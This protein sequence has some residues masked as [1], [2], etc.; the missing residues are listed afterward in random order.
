[1]IRALLTFEEAH[2]VADARPGICTGA[3]RG[4]GTQMA[5]DLE[6]SRRGET[7]AANA[8]LAFAAGVVQAPNA[9]DRTG[10]DAP[11]D[12]DRNVA[13]IA[14]H[15]A[16]LAL[17]LPTLGRIAYGLELSGDAAWGA[18]AEELRQNYP[19]LSD[20]HFA[21]VVLT[22]VEAIREC[23]LTMPA[24]THVDSSARLKLFAMGLGVLR[25][26]REAIRALLVQDID[27]LLGLRRTAYLSSVKGNGAA[28]RAAKC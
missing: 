10:E 13:T 16:G 14:A 28:A 11:D 5:A 1:M 15:I 19:D 26:R 3:D 21:G 6:S 22:T 2:E 8:M 4:W 24:G 12:F 7:E 9:S 23:A 25:E 18:L 27:T 17:S 20:L